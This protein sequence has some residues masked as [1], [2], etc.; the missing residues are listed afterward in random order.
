MAEVSGGQVGGGVAQGS[1]DIGGSGAAAGAAGGAAPGGTGVSG[2]GQA[3]PW[4]GLTEAADIAHVETKGWKSPADV[5]KSYRG[6]E[7]LLGRDPSTLLVIPRADDPVGFRAAMTRLGMPETHDK[8]EINVPK[9]VDPKYG[10]WARQ[11]FHKLGLTA[12]QAKDLSNANNEFAA[13]AAVESDK[14]YNLQVQTDKHAL[15]V[16]WGGGH[17]RMMSAA[18]TATRSLGMTGE[19]IDAL[20]KSMGYAGVMKYL[21]GLGQKMGEDSFVSGVS[22]PGFGGT[23]TP[24]EAKI[25]Y[26]KAKLDPNFTKALFDNQH[27][28]HKAA[29]TKQTQ[30]HALMYP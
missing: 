15:L 10:D 20:E 8:Y 13:A 28:G 26:E 19:M 21:A 4:H 27:P 9:G 25:E 12:S 17:E 23:M 24:E 16:E 7:T 1:A 3:A 2:T 18:Q 11:T 29:K 14:T 22:K 5:I 6:A 30:L